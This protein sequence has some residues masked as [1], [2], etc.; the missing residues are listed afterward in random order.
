MV[1][2]HWLAMFHRFVS[3]TVSQVCL[4]GIC[5]VVFASH[6][7]SRHGPGCGLLASQPPS[8]DPCGFKEHVCEAARRNKQPAGLDAPRGNVPRQRNFVAACKAGIV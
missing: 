5:F 8:D 2:E 7:S 4:I 3:R 6:E 1:W